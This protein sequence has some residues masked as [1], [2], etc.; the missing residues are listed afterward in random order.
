MSAAVGWIV[1][2]VA[3][4]VLV[5][6]VCAFIL[7]ALEVFAELPSTRER[8]SRRFARQQSAERGDR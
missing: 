3:L 1:V 5:V 6:G 2:L 8:R 4:V 7:A